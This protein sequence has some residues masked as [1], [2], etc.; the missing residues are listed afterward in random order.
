MCYGNVYII[1]VEFREPGE[2]LHKNGHVECGAN[3]MVKDDQFIYTGTRQYY[4]SKKEVGVV[5]ILEPMNSELNYFEYQIISRGACGEIGIGVGGHDYPLDK[6]PG[7]CQNGVG[8]H[9]DDGHLYNQKGSGPKFGPT[10]TEGDRMGCGIVFQSES[11]GDVDVFFTKN[12]QQVG[13]LVRFKKPKGGLYPL[14]GMHSEGEKV[15]Y[16]GHW[17]CLLHG[18]THDKTIPSNGKQI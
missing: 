15:Q 13:T 2:K 6:M 1:P 12:G 18:N 7:W 10:C 11:E 5:K 9:A 4:R 3:V 17:H 14:I 8:Y 16:L